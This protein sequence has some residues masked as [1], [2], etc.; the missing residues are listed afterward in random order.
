MHVKN[1]RVSSGFNWQ[2]LHSPGSI[3]YH[4][5]YLMT[6]FYGE[7]NIVLGSEVLLNKDKIIELE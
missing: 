3:Q 2:D 4:F 1:L 5:T 7:P 6:Q